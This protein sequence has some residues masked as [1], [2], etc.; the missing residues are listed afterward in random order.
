MEAGTAAPATRATPADSAFARRVAVATAVGVAVRFLALRAQWGRPNLGDAV[1]YSGQARL[2]ATGNGFRD[3]DLRAPGMAFGPLT[4]LVLAPVT[5]LGGHVDAQR[6]ALVLLGAAAIP[7]AALVGRRIAGPVVGAVAAFGVA[8]HPQMWANNVVVMSETVVALAVAFALLAALAY[9]AR[10]GLRT[11]GVLGAVIGVA[12]LARTE[13]VLLLALLA[14]P[15]VWR[16]GHDRRREVAAAVLACAAVVGPW[17]VHN[18]VR[19]D[20]PVLTEN[21]DGTLWRAYCPTTFYGSETGTADARCGLQRGRPGA[22]GPITYALGHLDRLPTV[23]AVRVARVWNLYGPEHA[24]YRGETEG[25]SRHL[26]WLTVAS[27][28]VVL[29]FAVA[30]ALRAR[31]LRLPLLELAAPIALVTLV[32][33]L[34]HPLHRYRASAELAVVVLAAIGV[35]GAASITTS[36]RTEPQP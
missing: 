30:G 13:Q 25:R 18:A 6:V 4:P 19:F 29:P 33:A 23:M 14:V 3:L 26:G 20:R 27:T 5:W 2:L 8:L 1:W 10:P 28:W 15:L 12:T 24:V 16:V 36:Q 17:V 35:V 34:V 7:L 9:R 32:V 31:R 11:A 21:A 22:T